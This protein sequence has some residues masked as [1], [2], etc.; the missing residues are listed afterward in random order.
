MSMETDEERYMQ[1]V[2]EIT[3]KNLDETKYAVFLFGSRTRKHD[4]KASDVDIG[5]LGKEPVLISK[6]CELK[7]AIEESIVPY[8]VDFVDFYGA[9][10]R[11]KK[12][13]LKQIEIWNQPKSIKLN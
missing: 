8:N 5:I 2:K 6:I 10:E 13:A 4:P 1:L 9:D 3:L 12:T 11:F 7:D